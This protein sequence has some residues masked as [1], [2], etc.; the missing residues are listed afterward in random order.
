MPM[1]KTPFAPAPIATNAE[2][3]Q[4]RPDVDDD[5]RSGCP[6]HLGLAT[7]QALLWNLVEN[8]R[9]LVLSHNLNLIG[10]RP[11]PRY[12]KKPCIIRADGNLSYH[13]I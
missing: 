8:T 10:F 1:R 9:P 4:L 5:L 12:H 2:I 6:T 7:H 11:F 3:L 13:E